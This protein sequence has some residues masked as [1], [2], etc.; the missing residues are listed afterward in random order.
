MGGVRWFH[1]QRGLMA[2]PVGI[3]EWLTRSRMIN[4]SMQRI[5]R[6]GSRCQAPWLMPA[7]C[8]PGPEV[9]VLRVS[10]LRETRAF[11]PDS[12]LPSEISSQ[13]RLCDLSRIFRTTMVMD[14][15]FRRAPKTAPETCGRLHFGIIIVRK[16]N[17]VATKSRYRRCNSEELIGWHWKTLR[18]SCFRLVG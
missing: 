4:K 16:G 18:R 8:V 12:T 1:P 7:P 6:R 9:F 5:I 15:A 13:F 14:V 10:L 11:L 2:P 3:Y 17:F